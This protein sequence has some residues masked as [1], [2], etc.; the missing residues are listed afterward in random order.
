MAVSPILLI[1]SSAVILFMIVFYIINRP[2]KPIFTGVLLC[3]LL[4][5]ALMTMTVNTQLLSMDS[6]VVTNKSVIDTFVSIIT[7]C[8]SP[9]RQTLAEAFEILCKID[10]GLM[11]SVILVMILEVRNLFRFDKK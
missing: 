7:M 11:V 8:D 4:C 1:I 6:A 9:S 5:Y 10:I 3:L 2:R